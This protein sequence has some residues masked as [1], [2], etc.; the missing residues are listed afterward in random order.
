[1]HENRE[2]SCTSC[3]KEQDR[4]A[5]AINRTADMDVQ[6]KSDCAVVPVNQSNKEAQ[7]SAEAGEGRAQTK[8]NIVQSHKLPTQSG[9]G[10]SQGL[11]GVRQ[12]ARGRKQERFTA[13]LHHLSI[14]LLRDSFYA[15]KRQA[16]P[17]VDGMRWQEY[18]T[19]LEDRL[20]DLHS[21]V[22]RGVYRAQPSRRVYIPKADGRQ[23]PLG[24]AAL[25]DKIVQQ[26]VVTILNQIY[27]VDFKG[28]SYGFRPGRS[29]HQ[30][31][32]ALTVGIQ[33][34]RVNW[35]LDAD[36]RG[37][38]DNMS[39]EWTMKFIEH[40]VADRRIL[41][42]IQKW[43]KAGVSEDGQWS[44]TKLG[45]PQGAVVSPLLA[46]VYL[47]Y[48][49]DQ[50]VEVWRKKVAEGDVIVVRYADDLVLGFQYRTEAERFLREF[51]ERL[52][53]FGLE[54]HADKTRLIE[55]GRFAA[56]GRKQRGQGKPETF[57]FLGFTHYCGQRHSSGAFIVWRITAKKRMAAKLNAIKAEL[58]RRKHHRTTEVGAWLRRVV[59]GYYQYHAVPGNTRQLRIFSRRVCW[60]WRT[61]LVRRSQRAQ[62]GWDRLYPLFSRWIP[63]PRILHPYPMARF[64]AIH[65]W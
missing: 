26:A 34:K 37:F 29:P 6:E 61:V 48:V 3:S 55:F 63:R 36:I 9:K 47:H 16:S 40:R 58:Q 1:M 23:R 46:N 35:V 5:K 64:A 59:R 50:W 60:L 8:E 25:E 41:R 7:A 21:R 49:F 13:L 14:E 54:L 62:V 57:T 44:E 19:G 4:S 24:I 11:R 27:E 65:P 12:A 51:R 45:T 22:H 42:L 17:G 39:H 30:A 15:L 31:L 18:E 2:I 32:D 38:F 33:W 28:F 53:K 20:T 43:L 56:R 10:L 52:A